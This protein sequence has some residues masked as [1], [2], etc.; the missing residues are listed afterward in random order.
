MVRAY[1]GAFYI[2]WMPGSA[3]TIAGLLAFIV[4]RTFKREED[5]GRQSYEICSRGMIA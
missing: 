5:V 2:P 3:Y 1:M 4:L